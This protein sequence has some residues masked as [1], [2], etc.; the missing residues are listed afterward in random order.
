MALSSLV[1]IGAGFLHSFVIAPIWSLCFRLVKMMFVSFC[2]FHCFEA[3]Q[4]GLQIYKQMPNQR[5]TMIYAFQR[6]FQSIFGFTLPL[7]HGRGLLNCVS[8]SLFSPS[9]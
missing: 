2:L 6:K 9:A 7:F 8:L 3:E 4:D 1:L 5:G